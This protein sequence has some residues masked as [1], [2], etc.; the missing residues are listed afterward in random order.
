M[1]FGIG[2]LERGGEVDDTLGHDRA[3]MGAAVLGE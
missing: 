3:D 2:G 1:N